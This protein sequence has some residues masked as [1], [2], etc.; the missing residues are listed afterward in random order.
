MPSQVEPFGFVF[1]E[2]M[3]QKLPCIGADAFA[4]PE[5][6]EHGSTGYVVPVG[7]ARALAERLI[8]VLGDPQAARQMGER[9]YARAVERYTWDGTAARITE[10]I[11]DLL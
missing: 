4:M 1:I 9:G 5:I 2:A 6:I 10:R 3:A 11:G 8:D 7:D